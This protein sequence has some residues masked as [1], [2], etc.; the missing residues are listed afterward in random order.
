MSSNP[1]KIFR[2]NLFTVSSVISF[3]CNTSFTFQNI[4]S[5]TQLDAKS[6]TSLTT[7][8]LTSIPSS[9]LSE[10]VILEN[11]LAYGLYKFEFRVIVTVN[12]DSQLSSNLAETYV[13]IIPTGLAV[14]SI[15]NGVSSVLIGTKQ[16]FDLKPSVFSRDF[17]NIIQPNQLNFSF[18]CKTVNLSDPNSIIN[19]TSK[20]DLLSYKN[21]QT[22][23][24]DRNVN[25][26]GNSS[27]ITLIF[28]KF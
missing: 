5:L 8:D 13:Q 10:L 14:I 22:L 1:K 27:K 24:M 26:F 21:N 6:L 18:Y 9:Q 3:Y 2:S 23:V 17:D 12:G 16:S 4:W 28:F 11:T 19:L 20:I 15:E 25:C 7:V